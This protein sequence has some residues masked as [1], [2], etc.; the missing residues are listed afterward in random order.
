MNLAP[1]ARS[2]P[3]DC[4][5][6]GMGRLVEKKTFLEVKECEEEEEAMRQARRRRYRSLPNMES[7]DVD[8]DEDAAE[9]LEAQEM[10]PA[11]PLPS[12]LPP[13]FAPDL[14]QRPV[15]LG[16][17]A[18]L[19]HAAAELPVKPNVK[20]TFIDVHSEDM[21][22]SPM[23]RRH[24]TCPAAHSSKDYSP[25]PSLESAE[26]DAPRY[27]ANGH[28]TT[29]SHA[30]MQD[31]QRVDMKARRRASSRGRRVSFAAQATEPAPEPERADPM[32]DESPV[33]QSRSHRQ[34]YFNTED[35]QD[36]LDQKAQQQS[37]GRARLQPGSQCTHE[38]LDQQQPDQEAVGATF[39]SATPRQVT[40]AAEEYADPFPGYYSRHEVEAGPRAAPAMPMPGLVAA[41]PAAS[42]E[43]SPQLSTFA[44]GFG[45]GAFTGFPPYLASVHPVQGVPMPAT[46]QAEW[47]SAWA[48]AHQAMHLRHQYAALL[49]SAAT[50]PAPPPGFAAPQQSTMPAVGML[51]PT[52][53]PWYPVPVPAS[54][55]YT[56]PAATGLN[57]TPGKWPADVSPTTSSVVPPSTSLPPPA[58]VAANTAPSLAAMLPPPSPQVETMRGVAGT[59]AVPGQAMGSSPMHQM[60]MASGTM[61]QQLHQEQHSFTV[62]RSPGPVS[63]Q[64][65]NANPAS[66]HS[67]EAAAEQQSPAA[68]VTEPKMRGSRRA[69][70]LWV[71]IYLHMKAPD[72]DLVPMLIGRGGCNM[73]RIAEQTDSKIRIRGQGSGHKEIDGKQEAPTPLMVAVTTHHTD[74]QHFKEAIRLT[75]RELS[76][77]SRRYIAHCEKHG[78][79]H[80]GPYYSV[81]LLPEGI[82]DQFRD[83]FEGVPFAPAPRNT[84]RPALASGE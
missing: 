47:H 54:S 18:A 12:A 83:V 10:Q 6:Q 23:A 78:Y 36:I 66:G 61:Q 76:T 53:S 82:E 26:D 46:G 67:L 29:G 25:T 39:H 19:D 31:F 50:A 15:L 44:S 49:G 28:T 65:A 57:A 80:E 40:G 75:L 59:I 73:R 63:M 74:H 45:P 60:M 35:L 32:S 71:H 84:G 33:F 17:S 21:S 48:Q 81:G 13:A 72:F 2:S 68:V 42:G 20:N 14:P 11:S 22:L 62:P 9:S 4:T 79:P 70:R 8:G 51:P 30:W 5:Q 77:A 16:R 27:N 24:V 3:D 58:P 41:P 69:P 55:W 37:F 38:K 64:P 43:E 7:G 1:V 52:V 34:T 56:R